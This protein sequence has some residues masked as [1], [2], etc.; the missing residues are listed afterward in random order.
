[1]ITITKQTTDERSEQTYARLTAYYLQQTDCRFGACTLPA[2]SAY[3]SAYGN[4]FL[5]CIEHTSRISMPFRPELMD[6]S[7]TI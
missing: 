7:V 6:R 5:Y 3:I 1:M 2:V 4:I